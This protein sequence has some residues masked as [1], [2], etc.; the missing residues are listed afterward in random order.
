MPATDRNKPPFL[1]ASA[2]WVDDEEVTFDHTKREVAEHLRTRL[3]ARIAVLDQVEVSTEE[4]STELRR[5]MAECAVD[6]NLMLASDLGEATWDLLR[7]RE[8]G[9][10]L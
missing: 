9:N 1:G 4:V 8:S 2:S 7:F 5:Q 3:L 6:G 10:S